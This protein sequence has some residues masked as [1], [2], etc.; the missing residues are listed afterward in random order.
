M[1][2]V[3]TE[4]YDHYAETITAATKANPCQITSA[5]HGLTTGSHVMLKDVG[6][7]TE[8]NDRRYI[9]TYVSSSAYT[10]DGIDS[11]NFT[12][13]TSGGTSYPLSYSLNHDFMGLYQNNPDT[14]APFIRFYDGTETYNVEQKDYDALLYAQN[15]TAESYP[16]N[17][18][19]IPSSTPTV[20]TST[21]TSAG[22]HSGGEST[23]TNTSGAFLTTNAIV[24]PGDEV[25]DKTLSYQG[26]VLSVTSAT[27]LVTALFNQSV[28]PS[29]YGSWGSG[30]SYVIIPQRRYQL[31]L[32]S[33][34][35]AGGDTI[36][37]PYLQS[38]A[39]VYSDYG[40]YDLP[41]GEEAILYY[42]AWFYK[43]RDREPNFGDKFYQVWERMVL[44]GI[45]NFDSVTRK[46]V[47]RPKYYI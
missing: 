17:F 11:T 31:V 12:T 18:A 6:G 23:L 44:D 46:T 29:S 15:D 43:Y 7:M 21:T 42:A 39:P 40:F 41:G 10:L 2:P 20:I 35:S 16:V 14:G 38:P 9:V 30:D 32:D 34:L 1:S 37:I 27:A 8:L 28:S 22:A 5:G 24:K 33:P 25:I 3:N 4:H 47:K 45:S 36:T 26:V 19:I 13:Y